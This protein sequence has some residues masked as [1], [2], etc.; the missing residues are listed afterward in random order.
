MSTKERILDAVR[1]LPEDVTFEDAMERLLL[2]SKIE[3][4]LAEAEGGQTLSDEQVLD[5]MRERFSL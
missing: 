3:R 4:G 1:A 5:R 2:L